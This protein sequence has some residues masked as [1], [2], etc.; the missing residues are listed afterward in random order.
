MLRVVILFCVLLFQ[1]D[2]FA[3]P[4]KDFSLHSQDLPKTLSALKGKV[5]Y[6]DF[7]ASWCAPCR[8]SFPWM[9][10]MQKQYGNDGLVVIAINVD[11]DSD[12]A[13]AFLLSSKPSFAIEYDPD[14]E[15]AQQ[16]QLTG[17][18]SSY[19][20]DKK[21]EIRFQH[22]GFFVNKQSAYEQELVSLLNETE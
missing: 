20:I 12:Q 14:G 2:V 22:Q 7:W 15:I 13:K 9:D 16:Y 6:V 17:M 4:A 19:V 11:S 18:P 1:N 21:G 8:Y 3:D 10:A 5:I